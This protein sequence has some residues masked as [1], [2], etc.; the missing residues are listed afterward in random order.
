M[1]VLPSV[2]EA[3]RPPPLAELPF[4][5][6]PLPELPLPLLLPVL[7]EPPFE[8][9]TFV[10]RPFRLRLKFTLAGSLTDAFPDIPLVL[11][12]TPVLSDRPEPLVEPALPLL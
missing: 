4:E 7:L 12:F 3:L 2:V 9:L 10:A 6:A 5:L 8:A 1:P 11:A